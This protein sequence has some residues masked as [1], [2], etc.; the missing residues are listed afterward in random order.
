VHQD[1]PSLALRAH[2]VLLEL[3]EDQRVLKDKQ[4]LKECKARRVLWVKR[5]PWEKRDI[6][7]P[8]G[9]QAPMELV[10]KEIKEIKE[11]KVKLALKVLMD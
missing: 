6:K 9:S 7:V 1:Y 10:L 8:W 11:I 4:D 3:L 2:K 5:G